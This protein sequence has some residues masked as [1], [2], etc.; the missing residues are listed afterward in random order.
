MVT[1]SGD[2]NYQMILAAK[3]RCFFEENKF[4]VPVSFLSCDLRANEASQNT[5]SNVHLIPKKK[6]IS[7]PFEVKREKSMQIF[8]RQIM[9][10]SGLPNKGLRK[11]LYV[12]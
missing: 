7:Y 4:I 5:A 6:V 2:R 3:R 10:P 1:P 12:K 9:P 11:K 8:L